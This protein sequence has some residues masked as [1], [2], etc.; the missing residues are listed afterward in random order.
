M[1]VFNL[2]TL[3]KVYSSQLK[4]INTLILYLAILSIYPQATLAEGDS[5]IKGQ[6]GGSIDSQG[7]GFIASRPNH[8]MK[9]NQRV[10]YMRLTVQSDGGQPTLL[11]LGPNSGDSFCVLGDEIS[12]L[13]PEIS[14]VWEE[15]NYDIYVG[16]RSGQQH[17]FVLDIST[18]N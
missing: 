6:S 4:I 3:R 15:G 5:I 18:D 1:T 10:D 13:K 14:G 8:Q 9:L 17:Q 11:V 16:D 12:G 2:S 7:C